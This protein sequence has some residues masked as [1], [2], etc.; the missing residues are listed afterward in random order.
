M[1]R[2]EAK[3]HGLRFQSKKIN[4]MAFGSFNKGFE[5]HRTDFD[6]LS[7]D[8]ALVDA[9]VSDPLCGFV[10]TAGLFRDMMDGL[11]VISKSGNLKKM[12]K[13][14]PVYFMS[15]KMDP[16]GGNGKGV[17]KVY[18]MFLSAGMKDVFYKFYEN[19][20]HEML[21][22]SNKITVYGDILNWINSKYD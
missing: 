18:D 19:G 20:R 1:S 14:L 2:L 12:N 22:E 3:K 8:G 15:G 4:D 11:A 6:W 13:D 5:P 21:N 9:Y 7:S 16:V 10:P 17:K